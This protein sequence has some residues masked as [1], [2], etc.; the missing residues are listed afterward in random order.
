MFKTLFFVVLLVLLICSAGQ[1]TS[2]HLPVF[3]LPMVGLGWVEEL[4]SL[5]V[6]AALIAAAIMVVVCAGMMLGG[7]VLL[8]L[9]L[10]GGTMAFVFLPILLP[11]V[12]VIALLSALR[13]RYQSG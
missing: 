6:S 1:H 10:V 12:L 4:L 11:L 2:V 8:A 13:P 5:V 3:D 9:V 7:L